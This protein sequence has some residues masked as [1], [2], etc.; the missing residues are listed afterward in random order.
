MD[1]TRDSLAAGPLDGRAAWSLLLSV[2]VGS[3]RAHGVAGASRH[4]ADMACPC[5]VFSVLS[6][7]SWALYKDDSLS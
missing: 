6:S 5:L 2:A 4:L 3:L 1:R 7:T